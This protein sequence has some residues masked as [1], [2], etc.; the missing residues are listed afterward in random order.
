M[1]KLN[2][3]MPEEATY[4]LIAV[5]LMWITNIGKIF[6][7]DDRLQIH[8]FLLCI[9]RSY[10]E[11]EIE[12][13]KE[14]IEHPLLRTLPPEIC[15]LIVYYIKLPNYINMFYKYAKIIQLDF[16][17][18]INPS[19]KSLIENGRSTLLNKALS[20]LYRP[21]VDFPGSSLYAEEYPFCGKW[22]R[23]IKDR[24][25][26]IR[27]VEQCLID[28]G[29]DNPDTFFHSYDGIQIIVQCSK[30]CGNYRHYDDPSIDNCL[31]EICNK[32]CKDPYIEEWGSGF[33][34][35]CICYNKV[36][37][38]AEPGTVMKKNRCEGCDYAKRIRDACGY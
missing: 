5:V 34:I 31:C 13:E 10:T 9:E 29:L 26:L 6:K 32:Y 15:N 36:S 3:E 1:P 23:C 17:S 12:K 35:A 18:I 11:G 19:I 22:D 33:P 14:Q 30:K 7:T 8:N 4:C 20:N 25:E 2:F 24:P 38:F 21:E 16:K 37:M 28:F 27:K